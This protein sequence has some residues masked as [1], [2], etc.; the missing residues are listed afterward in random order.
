MS[1]DHHSTAEAEA[2]LM[3]EIGCFHPAC[4]SDQDI[5]RLTIVLVISAVF[6]VAEFV[7]GWI[8]NSLALLA[9]AGHMLTDVAAI[10]L[11]LFASKIARRPVTSE[12]TF[13]Y[14]RLE[15]LA[16]LVNGTTLFVIAG[17]IVWEALQ[18]LST[19]IEIQTTTMMV[20]AV[21][22]LGANL[23]AAKILH[24]NHDH[25]LNMRGAYLHVLSDLLGSIGA[26]VAGIVIITTGWTAADAVVSVVIALLIVTSA[27]RLVKESV[28][29]LLEA[30]PAHVDVN[31]VT[32]ALVDISGISGVHDVHV[33]TVTSGVVAMSAH[34]MVD[35]PS[36]HQELLQAAQARLAQFG[37]QHLTL[38]LEHDPTCRVC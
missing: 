3:S 8:S 31:E 26:I 11:S 9:D 33:W 19:P 6:M 32:Q 23:L 30:S 35:E 25:S 17:G 38:Q 22:G 13:G 18:R 4:L 15:I 27:W 7:G 5:K 28:D 34:A 10:A 16:A 14:L 29:V 1:M 20:V 12:K 21:F 37:I 24:G 36:R 2:P